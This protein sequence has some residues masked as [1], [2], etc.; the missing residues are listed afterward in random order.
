MVRPFVAVAA[1]LAI[2][3][4]ATTSARDRLAEACRQDLAHDPRCLEVLTTEED[5]YESR[6]EVMAAEERREAQAFDTR[7]A[8]LRREEEARQLARA[9]TS[10]ASVEET[11]DPEGEADVLPEDVEDLAGAAI[12][13]P[14]GLDVGSSVRALEKERAR[15][16]AAAPAGV[17]PLPTPEAYLRGARCLLAADLDALRKTFD[18]GKRAAERPQIAVVILD[19]ERLMARID[20]EMKHRRLPPQDAEC[21][22]HEEVMSLLRS[23][24]GPKLDARGLA[25][26]TKELEVRAGLPRAE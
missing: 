9:R 13:L 12:E 17:A 26:I 5:G 22:Q 15:A 18:E 14:G 6:A 16:A 3:A 25:R 20:D 7:L 8:R 11:P 4:C 1:G 23:L 19:S 24:V 2:A 21:K 10:S